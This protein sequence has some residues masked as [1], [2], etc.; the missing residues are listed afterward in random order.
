MILDDDSQ[1]LRRGAVEPE[2]FGGAHR[3]RGAG[4]G[5]FALLVAFRLAHVVQQQRQ[6]EQT[7]AFEA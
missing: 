4:F 6:V 7:R 2:P 3:Q 5:V 1:G